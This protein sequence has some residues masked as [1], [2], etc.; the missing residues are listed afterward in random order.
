MRDRT[1]KKTAGPPDR[2][3]VLPLCDKGV[4][5][6]TGLNGDISKP[7]GGRS[8]GPSEPPFEHESYHDNSAANHVRCPVPGISEDVRE[9][10]ARSTV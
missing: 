1:R 4:D 8:S 2:A 3:M 7:D 6:Q 10:A 5:K 9:E